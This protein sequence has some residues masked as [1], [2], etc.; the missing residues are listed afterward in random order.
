M[1][2]IFIMRHPRKDSAHA[3]A[4]AEKLRAR[5]KWTCGSIR[6]ALRLPRKWSKEIGGGGRTAAR[7]SCSCF[8]TIRSSRRNVVRE[9]S[10]ASEKRPPYPS[11][12]R[13]RILHFPA[14]FKYQLCAG[15]QRAQLPDFRGH[16]G[17]LSSLTKLGVERITIVL[18]LRVMLLPIAQSKIRANR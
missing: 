15:I 6:L 12:S 2:D 17:V 3:L 5:R 1:P 9:L 7:R 16:S 14:E 8:R 13:S 11:P 18:L 10:I 4:L